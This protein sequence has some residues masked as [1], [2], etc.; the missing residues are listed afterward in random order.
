MIYSFSLLEIISVI[1]WLNLI[2]YSNLYSYVPYASMVYMKIILGISFMHSVFELRFA[3]DHFFKKTSLERYKRNLRVTF[4]IKL[5]LRLL[6]L[7]LFC[8]DIYFNYFEKFIK[9]STSRMDF[10]FLQITYYIISV[11]FILLSLSLVWQ[12]VNILKKVRRELGTNLSH[13]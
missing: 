1:T 3:I 9:G 5:V 10:T 4:W 6:I 7:A 11:V 2:P 12:T 13:E 8:L